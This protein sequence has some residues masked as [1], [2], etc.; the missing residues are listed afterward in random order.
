MSLEEKEQKDT[1][2]GEKIDN[3][4]TS[5]DENTPIIDKNAP[6]KPF[7][8]YLRM[9][10]S[11]R[12]IPMSAW[13][14]EPCC[15]KHKVG[16]LYVYHSTLDEDDEGIAK[17][18]VGPCWPMIILVTFLIIGI[19]TVTS[20][21]AYN[22]N[23]NFIYALPIIIL[24]ALLTLFFYY[25]TACSNPGIQK[26]NH[27]KPNEENGEN[28]FFDERIKSFRAQDWQYDP[29]TQLFIKKIDHFCPWTGTIIASG[30]LKDFFLFNGFLWC[31]CLF[32]LGAPLLFISI[33]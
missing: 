15:Y 29:E 14:P 26:R 19:P 24:G 31:L 30:N 3:E 10:P 2:M 8:N 6:D 16:N 23:E 21:F 9:K 27:Q 4:E 32:G 5:A 22:L 28:W 1:E 7:H 11:T 18:M 13:V 33:S 20:S 17:C 12:D 25:R